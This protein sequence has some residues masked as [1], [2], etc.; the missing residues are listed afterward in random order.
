MTRY[1]PAFVFFV[2]FVPSRYQ[3]ASA[4]TITQRGFVEGSI[5]LFPQD[6]PNDATRVVGDVL[7]RDE[8][9]VKPAPWMQFAGGVDLRL[10]SHDQT[11]R[12]WRL[13]FS[14]RGVLRPSIAVRRL[15]ATVTHKAL[16]VDA[17]KQ[18]I[19]WGKTDIVT[20]TDRFAP[21]DFTNVVDTEFLAVTG[22]RAAVQAGSGSDAGH[23]TFEV[24]WVPRLTPSRLP[25]LN[26]RWTA[27]PP[28]AAGI[29]IVDAGAA[30]P[31]GS[32]T[33][34]RWSHVGAAI[35]YSLSYF[36]GFNHLPNIDATVMVSSPITST[37]PVPSAVEG[38]IAVA[39]IYPAIRS[40]G[41][42]LAMPTR[43]LTIKAETAYFTST[44]PE[45]DE[46]VIYVVQL[47]RQTGEWVLVAGYAGEA[48]TARRAALTFA[49]D[50][51]LARAIVARASYTIDATRSVALESA[52]R[53]SGGGVYVK[54]EY[55]QAHGQHWRAT[56]TGVLIA[57]ASD[58]FLGQYRRNSHV[59]VA[60]RYS[61]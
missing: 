35:E 21:R 2:F 34:V 37:A 3:D 1:I 19:R 11:D 51:G 36:D 45:T 9:F 57:G 33:G 43:W 47:E 4:Q 38:R 40:Y 61:F 8:V 56:I 12:A 16:A 6:A 44:T 42:D 50:R 29:P 32:Q 7:A 27:V 48:V 13:D 18:F 30:L 55:S 53:Q 23:D 46:Y 49:P 28:E 25:L 54:G 26:Q 24:V 59:T 20:P 52:V 17:G 41:A 39:R 31:E 22:V 10:N 14:D 15:S 58:D 60:L 5:V